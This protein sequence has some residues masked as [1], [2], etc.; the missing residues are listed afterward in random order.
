MGRHPEHAGPATEASPRI[1]VVM[2][3][4]NR[5]DEAVA[6][7]DRLVRLPEQPEV[8]V[9]DNA[10]TDGTSDRLAAR[11]FP[12]VTLIRCQENLGAAGRNV[13]VR[14]TGAPFVAF[15]DD[16]TAWLPGSLRRAA[17][18]LASHPDLGLICGR[19]VIGDGGREDP[20]AA[21]MAA[22]PLPRPPGWPG[23]P[24]LGFLA[25]ASVVRRSAFLA[26]G[27]FERRFVV[28]GE[29]ELLALDLAAAGWGLSYIPDIVVR[30]DPSPRRDTADRRRIQARNALWSTWL[31]HPPDLAWAR[32]ARLGRQALYDSAVR[33]GFTEAARDLPWVIRSRRRLPPA[34]ANAARQLEGAS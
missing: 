1:A 32:T 11:A 17:E 10:S 22:S 28:G 16:D 34:V 14:R 15:C 8:V 27:G 25:C 4:R 2:I 33:R 30:H 18:L 7:V 9:V 13:G 29:E 26:A 12:A 19:V 31:R 20:I 23:Y 3:T 6:A 5:A 24:I 21:V